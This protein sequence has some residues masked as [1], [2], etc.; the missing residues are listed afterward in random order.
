[1]SQ[2]RAGLTRYLPQLPKFMDRGGF[3]R[4]DPIR[5][6]PVPRKNL[7]SNPG[8]RD[9]AGENMR[10]AIPWGV[11]GGG[12]DVRD[13]ARKAARREGMNLSEWLA[14]VVGQYA[15]QT[16][17]D[18]ADLDEDD[19]AEAIAAQL[20]R[21]GIEAGKA[22]SRHG[23]ARPSRGRPQVPLRQIQR[24][25]RRVAARK[26]LRASRRRGFRRYAR[27]P[28]GR[29]GTRAIRGG[30]TAGAPPSAMP[31]PKSP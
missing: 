5:R 14:Q 25:H 16:G 31:L 27:W 26:G 22:Q 20:R 21:L 28:Q 17:A 3:E 23:K 6:F 29:A 13:A 7:G 12:V 2:N 30:A 9:P 15:A 24:R 1:M 8:S 18:P 10:K 11:R 4:P 19:C